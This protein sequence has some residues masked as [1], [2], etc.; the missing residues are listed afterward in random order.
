MHVSCIL[1]HIICRIRISVIHSKSFFTAITL[2]P[3]S[4]IVVATVE[5]RLNGSSHVRDR[6]G[7]LKRFPYRGEIPG[8][9]AAFGVQEIAQIWVQEQDRRTVVELSVIASQSTLKSPQSGREDWVKGKRRTPRFPQGNSS[10]HSSSAYRKIQLS[11]I[12]SVIQRPPLSISSSTEP[13]PLPRQMKAQNPAAT[14]SRF[15]GCRAREND[16][17]RHKP[18]P[19]TV[20]AAKKNQHEPVLPMRA[21]SASPPAVMSTVGSYPAE[22]AVAASPCRPPTVAGDPSPSC[23]RPN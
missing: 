21:I 4:S 3:I 14:W 6:K 9:L 2:I 18:N 7:G 13:P 16:R 12:I 5:Q 23:R 11:A 8:E 20:V 1:R 15:H 22:A 17:R 19:P 10:G